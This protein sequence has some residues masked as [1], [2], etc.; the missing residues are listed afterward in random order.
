MKKKPKDTFDDFLARVKEDETTVAELTY[1]YWEL[2]EEYEHLDKAL[3]IQESKVE[4]LKNKC[5]CY[6]N[7][8][9]T[10]ELKVCND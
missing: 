6:K 5:A 3:E 10:K 8:Q 9:M 2:L 4:T 1:W 7:S